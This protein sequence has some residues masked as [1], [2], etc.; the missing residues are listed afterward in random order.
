MSHF[1]SRIKGSRGEAT[2]CGTKSSGI[3]A[4]ATGWD[5]GGTCKVHFNPQLGTDVVEFYLTNGSNGHSS[6]RVAA[7][8]YIN[9]TLQLLNTSYPELFL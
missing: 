8:A 2:R 7:F 9:N 5:I 4:N 1:Y 3:R 6:T